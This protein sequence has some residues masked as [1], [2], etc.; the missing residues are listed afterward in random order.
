M[1][2][3]GPTSTCITNVPLYITNVVAVLDTN[4]G[5]TVTFD[6]QGG[7]N[8]FLYD[9]FTTTALMG[10]NAII[11][12]WFWL[13]RGPTCSTYEYSGQH[14]TNAFYVLGGIE[15]ADNDGMTDAWEQLVS[16]TSRTNAQPA[17][18]VFITDVVGGA[19]P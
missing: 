6:V 2:L 11:S 16:K 17:F 10:T 8:G 5:T 15:D 3:V 7:T 12:Q 4:T 14:F 1:M 18:K 19:A 9:I 13:E